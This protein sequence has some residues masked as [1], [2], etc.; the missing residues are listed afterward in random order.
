MP[1]G[2]PVHKIYAGLIREGYDE[3]SAAR[4]AQSKTGLS[5]RTGKPPMRKAW[6]SK[7]PRRLTKRSV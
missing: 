3:G 4:I 7:F 5:L 1:Q 6:Q 2:T